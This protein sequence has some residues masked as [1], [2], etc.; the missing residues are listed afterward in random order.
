LR[1]GAAGGYSLIE[2]LFASFLLLVV[3]ISIIPMF[4]RALQ[5]NL[6]GGRSS[7]IA[8]FVA[9]DMEQAN[10]KFIDHEDFD[11]V[12]T[13]FVNVATQYWN[14]GT[15]DSDGDGRQLLGDE[16]WQDDNSSGSILWER[17]TEVRKYGVSDI[18]PVVDTT[19]T[20]LTGYGENP[21]IFDL[22]LSPSEEGAKHLVEF[23]VQIK[24][25]TESFGVG[26]RMTVSHFRT[27]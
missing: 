10:Q 24:P 6:A 14:L 22:P 13:D 19:G 5:S 8:T 7:A 25:Y 15:S 23:R 12:G 18:L 2:V 9:S 11:L 26:K 27:Y 1:G 17:T 3:A 16:V 4:T 21:R 20:I